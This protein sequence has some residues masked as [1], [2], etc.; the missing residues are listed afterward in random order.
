[1]RISHLVLLSAAL[2]SVASAQSPRLAPSFSI[3][4]PGAAPLTLESYRG[5]IV[6]LAFIDTTCSHCQ[7][8]TREMGP[9]AVEYAP[10]GVQIL[11]CAFNTGAGAAVQG[12]IQQFQPT[13]PIG[14][15]DRAAVYTFLQRSVIDARPLYVPHL[16]VIDRKGLIQ[17]DYAGESPF[18]T[19]PIVNLRQQLDKMLAATAAPATKSAK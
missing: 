3:Q 2:A 12:F 8:L 10:K 11:E 4:R 16:I 7:E 5:K 1:M 13:F 9:L 15:A 18:M 17:G 19:N 6:A 14:W